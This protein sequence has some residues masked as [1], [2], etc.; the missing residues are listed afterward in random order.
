M[1]LYDLIYCQYGHCVIVDIIDDQSCW[2]RDDMGEEYEI[3][4]HDIM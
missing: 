4:F 1:K 2:V 3:F